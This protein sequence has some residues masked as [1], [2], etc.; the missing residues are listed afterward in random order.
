MNKIL[1]VGAGGHAKACIDVIETQG[2]FS[3]VGLVE[4]PTIT[5]RKIFNYDIIG[6]DNDLGELFNNIKHALVT[7]G[8]IKNP[9][10][11]INL[12]SAL[13]SLGYTLPVIVSNNAHVSKHA[14]I[15]EGT[16]IMHGV[17][18]NA[19]ARIGINCIINNQSL[20]EHDAVISDHCHIATGA[21]INGE[22][23]VGEGSF[24]G[25][26]V[27]INHRI[28]IGRNC[29]IGSGSVIKTNIPD[30]QLNKN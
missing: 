18:V 30:N 4:K 15:D 22:A 10:T 1:L 9:N 29:V 6:T 13:K 25:S 27:V 28:N 16:I 3:I 2:I 19:G 7:V 26:G 20:I 21:I 12:Y 24:I 11:R 5:M 17:V 23:K 14:K 8:Q